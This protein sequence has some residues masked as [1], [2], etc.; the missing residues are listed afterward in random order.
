MLFIS[1]GVVDYA[2]GRNRRCRD[3]IV[4]VSMLSN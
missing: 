3:L 2:T 1:R 4:V